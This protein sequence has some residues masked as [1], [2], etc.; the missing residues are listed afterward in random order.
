MAL[1][2]TTPRV[3]PVPAVAWRELLANVAAGKE[4][5]LE[6]QLSRDSRAAFARGQLRRSVIDAASASEI[7]LH[8]LISTTVTEEHMPNSEY[9]KRLKKLDKQP[10]GELVAI[11]EKAG[12]DRTVDIAALT[13][14]VHVRNDAIHRGT[15]PSHVDAFKAMQAAVDLLGR[16]GP[17][18]RSESQPDYGDD[19]Q[20]APLPAQP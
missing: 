20:V 1:T 14:L 11:A 13:E 10:L 15:T 2:L 4:P 3:M 19:W 8:R 6:E 17:W 18:K 7:V 12:I 9:R 16:H 5:P